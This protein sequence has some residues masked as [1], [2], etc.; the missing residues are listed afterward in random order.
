MWHWKTAACT[1]NVVWRKLHLE[2]FTQRLNW[3][4]DLDFY[5]DA[6]ETSDKIQL[7]PFMYER[8]CTMLYIL[9]HNHI[10]ASVD[11]NK[12]YLHSFNCACGDIFMKIYAKLHRFKEKKTSFF[13]QMSVLF[14]FTPVLL[15][16]F[17]V[18][19]FI[20]TN[21]FVEVRWYE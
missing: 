2:W 8:Q 16:L 9:M 14:G 19:H 3:F 20:S 1:I 12:K 21:K 15:H 6:A 7:K 13:F 10:I 11:E 4:D 18:R 5:L 17:G